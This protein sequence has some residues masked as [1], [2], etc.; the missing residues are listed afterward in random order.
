[1][2]D[3]SRVEL[4]LGEPWLITPEG[5]QQIVAIAERS[6]DIDALI[7]RSGQRLQY[8]RTVQVRDGTAVIPVTG[9]IF[10]YANIFSAISGATSTQVLATDFRAALDDPLVRDIV[11]EFNSPGGAVEGINE[12][13]DMVFEARSEGKRI[14][15]YA[16]G[17]MAS[18]AYWIGSAADEVVASPTGVIGSIGAIM[19]ITDASGRDAR[20]GV[21]TLQIVSSQSPDKVVDPYGDTGRAK[22]QKIVDDLAAV[23]VST[24]ARNRDVEVETVLTEFGGGG[25][26][27]GQ[28]AVD[29]GLADRLGSLE[30]VLAE[31]SAARQSQRSRS[32]IMSKTTTT[33]SAPRGPI[34]VENTEQLR[35]ALQAGHT[36]DE[37]TIKAVDV[38]KIETDARA[39]GVTAFR[40]GTEFAKAITDAKTEATKAERDRVAALQ[41]ITIKGFEKELTA[42]I[43]D[44]SSAEALAMA[45]SKAVRERGTSVSTQAADSPAA[46]K[47]GG[48]TDRTTSAGGEKAWGNITAKFKRKTG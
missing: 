1:M 8:T 42:A 10:R 34:T 31:L 13:G 41:E 37:I 19:T 14:I 46:I 6:H 21:R 43:K 39:A 12:L 26:M 4:A 7:A 48:A 23:F 5:M 40:E 33:G 18:A 22:L 9:P 16:G 28:A 20:A 11:F 29:A 25:V 27:V 35:N 32:F 2:S 38:A 36:A 44:G 17:N 24:V 47:H 15:A 45:Q 3:H 30:S